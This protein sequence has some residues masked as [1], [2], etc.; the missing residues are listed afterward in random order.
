MP[1]AVPGTF[2]LRLHGVAP[3]SAVDGPGLR[4]AV[5]VQGCPH[6]CPGCHNPQSHDPR[7]GYAGDVRELLAAMK[8]NPLL[9]GVTLSGGEPFAQAAPL[10]WLAAEVRALE[11]NVVTYSG[12]TLEHL[13]ALARRDAAVWRLLSLTDLLIDGPYVQALRDLEL[14]LCGSSNQ[15]VRRAEEFWP[16]LEQTRV[17]LDTAQR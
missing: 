2:A 15:R 16:L 4:Y 12:Y 1:D 8:E 14:P 17:D 10:A 3:E 9:A 11:K 13:L 6:D 7:G 5:F